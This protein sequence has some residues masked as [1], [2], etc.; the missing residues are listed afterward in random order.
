M[1]KTFGNRGGDLQAW[2]KKSRWER[3]REGFPRREDL[4]A[5]TFKEGGT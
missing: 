5:G 4:S 3:N 2:K 1:M